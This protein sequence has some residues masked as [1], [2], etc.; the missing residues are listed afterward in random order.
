[1][2]SYTLAKL[3]AKVKATN[4]ANANAMAIYTAFAP[5]AQAF[6]GQKIFKADGE[7]TKKFADALPKLGF[8]FYRYNSSYSLV[9]IAKE[10]A[11]IEG[12]SSC[13]YAEASCY[14]ASV[15]LGTLVQLHDAPSLRVDWTVEEVANL[16]KAAEEANEKARNAESAL[17]SFGMYDR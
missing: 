3:T 13:V 6:I 17:G 15:T 4:A 2:N 11:S 10:S 5:I 16:R 8:H 1:M 7:L 14:V 9:Y 12:H